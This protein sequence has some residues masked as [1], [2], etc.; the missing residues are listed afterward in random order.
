MSIIKCPEC[1]HEVSTKAP[2][3][4]NCG[5]AIQN[6]IKRCPICN[7]LVLMDADQCPHCSARFLVDKTEPAPAATTAPVVPVVSILAAV[8]P[9]TADA[10]EV[11]L[12]APSFEEPAGAPPAG[13]KSGSSSADGTSPTP[14]KDPKKKSSPW[15]LLVLAIVIVAVGGFFYF[16]YQLHEATEEKDYESLK[17]CT[18]I[19]NYQDFINRYPESRHIENVRSRL[20]ELQRIENEWRSACNAK[21]SHQLQEFID[22]NPTSI[23]KSTALFKIDS[24]D[25]V[26]ADRKGTAAAY[27]LYIERHEDGE[28]IDQAYIERDRASVREAKARLD[29]INAA[30]NE[31]RDSLAFV[32]AGI[33][34]AQ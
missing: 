23:H 14:P 27:N 20:K 11:P 28:H 16:S 31:L 34:A 18:E 10:E 4:P 17:G 2:T 15:W 5:V 24:L 21:D 29:S 12:P 33:P 1:G 26:E 30:Q 32:Q 6:N 8:S 25:W 22:Q 9:M 3:C 19:E 7:R 13:T